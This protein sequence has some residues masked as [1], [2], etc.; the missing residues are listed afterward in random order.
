MVAYLIRDTQIIPI[1]PLPFKVG[2][3]L[4]N[5]LVIQE[6]TLS[7]FHAEIHMQDDHYVLIDC[8]S[9]GGTYLNSERVTNASLKSGDSI[10]LAATALVFVDNAPQ[11]SK[12]AAKDTD[13]LKDPMRDSEPTVFEF[14]PDWRPDDD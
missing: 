13:A 14:K 5:D 12:H 11:L 9:S 8:N 4:E 1:K 2:R 10:V 6:P 7:R 3:A